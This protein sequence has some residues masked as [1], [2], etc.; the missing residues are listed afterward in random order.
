MTSPPRWFLLLS[1]LCALLASLPFLLGLPGGFLLDDTIN[2]V[3]NSG[4]RLQSLDPLAVLEAASSAQIGGLTRVLPTLTFAL[5]HFR[6]NGLDPATFKITNIAIH[7]LT[8]LVLAFFLRTLLL[9][10]GTPATRARWAALAMAFAWALH[11]LHVS[12]VLYIVQRMQTMATLFIVLALLSYLKARTAQMAG[13][14]SRTNWM[15]TGLLWVLAIACKEDAIL[16]PAY[17]LALELTVLRFQASDFGLARKLRHGYLFMTVLGIAA[18]LLVIA[19]HYWSWGIADSGRDFSSTERLLTQGRVLCMYLWESVLPLPSHMPFYYDW[20]QPSRGLLQPWTT[21]P[22]LLLLLALLGT[23]VHLRH[24]RPV[25]ALGV[26]LFFAGHFITSNVIVLELAFEHRNQFPLI[27]IV[28][29]VG[30]LLALLAGRLNAR[31]STCTTACVLLFLTL[32]S[33]TA[34]RAHSWNSTLTTARTSTQLAPTSAR[35]WN[36]LCLAWLDLGGGPKHNNPNLDKA[37]VACSKG[38]DVGKDSVVGMANVIAI[39]TIQ[40]TITSTDWERYLDQLRRY[41]MTGENAFTIWVILNRAR[42]GMHVDGDRMFEAIEITDR[43]RPFTTVASAAIG[44]FILGHT[45]QPDRAYPYFS[46]AVQ[47]AR[48][49]AF[50]DDIIADLRKEGRQDWAENLERLVR[51]PAIKTGSRPALEDHPR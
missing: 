9:I 25:F 3:E 11:P 12:S 43:R 23:A 13:A 51:N 46:R 1:F 6:G 4:I 29:A 47:T 42:D 28:L 30:D 17:A 16:L 7:A 22:S 10:A 36:S 32:A 26:F 8:T 34:V 21:L 40:G 19:P 31:T 24:R 35:A 2:I 5:D 18:F 38:A 14:S 45:L 33:A 41:P 44:Y 20:V 49:P 39:K 27:G 37:V 15:L 48:D 50:A